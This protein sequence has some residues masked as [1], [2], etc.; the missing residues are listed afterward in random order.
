MKSIL[1]VKTSS[2]GDVVH[3][4]PVASDLHR[5]FPEAAIDWAVEEDFI[6]IPRAHEAVR[7]ALPVAIRRWRRAPWRRPVVS[8]MR[9]SVRALREEQ[10]DAVIDTQGLFKS[11]LVASAARG[12]RYGLDWKSAREPLRLFY[13]H[14]FSVPWTLHAVARNRN[15]AA[16][17][18]NYTPP[19]D[20]DYGI[21]ATAARFAWLTAERYAV[22]V[23][24][25][26]A[27]AKLWPEAHWRNLAQDLPGRGIA[28]VLPWGGLAERE[29]AER[30]ARG[31]AGM[32]VAPRLTL[33]EVMALFAGAHAVVGVDTGLTHLAGALGTPTIGIYCAT[34]PA[35]TGLYG[36]ARAVNV[37]GAAG[38]PP[39]EDV[40]RALYELAP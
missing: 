38:A 35:Q 13:Q 1:L 34:A 24:A 15:L 17:A 7:R 9:Q 11:A 39:V 5:V 3:N 12:E 6:E 23:H 37:G 40:V 19:A 29:R 21:R 25:T 28:C 36:C 32:V 26:S 16:Q 30:I 18:L 31:M 2:L 33:T 4:L 27:Q 8:E 10:Y 14:T 22:L 20:V